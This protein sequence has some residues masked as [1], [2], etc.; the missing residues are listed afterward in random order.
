MKEI[1]KDVVKEIAADLIRRY[2][3][4]STLEVKNRLREMNYL[5][6][7]YDVTVFLDMIRREE[8]W[9]CES[10]G[11][12][13]VYYFPNSTHEVFKDCRFSLN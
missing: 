13:M 11:S 5:A 9:C 2:G 7:H 3:S 12:L 6:L 10:N 4:A 1:T 8:N